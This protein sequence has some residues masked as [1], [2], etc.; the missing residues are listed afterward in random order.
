MNG[1]LVYLWILIFFLYIT[2]SPSA[3]EPTETKDS[4]TEHD[5]YSRP[6]K[7]GTISVPAKYKRE[8]VYNRIAT[9]PK[10]KHVCQVYTLKNNHK[11]QTGFQQFR[12]KN[13]TN[14]AG[15]A[16]IK[17]WIPP[18]N[19]HSVLFF[20]AFLCNKKSIIEPADHVIDIWNIIEM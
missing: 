5:C 7:H 12:K 3:P 4:W 11:H 2:P 13:E 17:R 9:T 20:L 18:Q 16:Q 14:T 19:D 8:C 15:S 1:A 6:Q 10:W